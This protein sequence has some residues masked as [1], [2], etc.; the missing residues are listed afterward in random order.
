[1]A[2]IILILGGARSGKSRFAQQLAERIGGADVLFVA[3]AEAGDSEMAHRIEAHRNSRPRA[4]STLEK[5]TGVSIALDGARA[6]YQVVLIDCLTLLASNVLMSC[7]DP[8]DV[9]T[10]D[11]R[12]RA[13]TDD[14]LGACR[15]RK[16]TVIIVSSEVGQG[17]VP[18][19]PLGR[20]YRDILGW[21][22]QAVAA[23]A[24]AV[25]LMVAGLPVEVKCLATTCEQ[26]AATASRET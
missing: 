10:A 25:Y 16:G 8:L 15:Q 5:T 17:L 21:T 24:D 4:W 2:R 19:N 13:E 9:R 12:M 22:N 6:R 18:D 3:T 7:R 1:M 26:A 20:V 23:Q 11:E 14:L